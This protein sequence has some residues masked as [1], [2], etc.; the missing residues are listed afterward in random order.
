MSDI[1]TQIEAQIPRLRRYALVLTHSQVEADELV[2]DCLVRALAKIHLWEDGTNLNAWLFTI[3]HNQYVNKVRRWSRE[4]TSVSIDE[5]EPLLTRAATQGARLELH[6]LDR[7]LGQLPK[8][9]RT[10]V[11]L[12]G[13]EGMSYQAVADVFGV[14]IGTIRSRLSRARAQLRRQIGITDEQP[15]GRM[16]A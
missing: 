7:A 10:V 11:L 5:D 8:E 3:M 14:P 9:T 2:Q 4:G 15:E 16:A 12:I 6:D 1:S 13:L